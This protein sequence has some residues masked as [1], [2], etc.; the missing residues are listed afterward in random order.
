MLRMRRCWKTAGRVQA[1]RV[2][3]EK[4]RASLKGRRNRCKTE[5][6]AYGGDALAVEVTAGAS[7]EVGGATRCTEILCM[8]KSR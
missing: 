6:L 8:L 5:E 2:F 4:R 7:T 1:F 3:A